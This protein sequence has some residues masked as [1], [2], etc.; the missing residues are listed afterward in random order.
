VSWTVED[1]ALPVNARFLSVLSGVRVRAPT[2]TSRPL[3]SWCITPP[4]CRR[5]PVPRGRVPPA[6]VWSECRPVLGQYPGVTREDVLAC[7]AYGSE[8]SRERYV[9]IPMAKPA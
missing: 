6:A 1:G 9:D 5:T 4:G 3:A 2:F 7:I 8:M